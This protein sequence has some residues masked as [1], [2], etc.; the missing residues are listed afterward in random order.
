M[1]ISLMGKKIILTGIRK[2]ARIPVDS[3]FGESLTHRFTSI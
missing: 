2:P 3:S 1:T